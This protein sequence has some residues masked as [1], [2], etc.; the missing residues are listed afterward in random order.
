M[1]TFVGD[2]AGVAANRVAVDGMINAEIAHIGVVHCSDQ[3]LERGK[4]FRRV[5]IHFYVGDMPRVAQRVI[6]SL[7]ANFVAGA[8]REVNRHVA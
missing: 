4:I 5:A 8:Y 6:R 2:D 1:R 7:N 3:C